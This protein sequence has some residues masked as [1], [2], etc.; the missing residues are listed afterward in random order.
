MKLNSCVVG[1]RSGVASV[2]RRSSAG[3]S[4]IVGGEHWLSRKWLEE[5]RWEV[6]YLVLHRSHGRLSDDEDP[7]L[8][9]HAHVS[10]G[11]P[12][13]SLSAPPPLGSKVLTTP[14]QRMTRVAAG[15]VEQTSTAWTARRSF[16]HSGFVYILNSDSVRREVRGWCPAVWEEKW[17]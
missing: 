10:A 11:P 8:L 15:L 6:G 2:A 1:G 4:D 3:E 9:T 14:K 13:A 7:A 17:K 5:Q 16:R 12:L